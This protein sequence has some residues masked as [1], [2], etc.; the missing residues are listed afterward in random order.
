[1][2]ALGWGARVA[3]LSLSL[4]L[5]RLSWDWA[6][7]AAAAQRCCMIISFL[8]KTH[9]LYDRQIFLEQRARDAQRA[10]SVNDWRGLYAIV[11]SLGGIASSSTPRPVN[12]KTG[13]SRALKK[14]VRCGGRSIFAKSLAVSLPP[15]SRFAPLLSNQQSA[16]NGA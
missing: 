12:R 3:A 1:M 15:W 13:L 11:R 9:V 16:V 5:R 6:R 8:I 2:P 4:S 10:A 7:L 14:L